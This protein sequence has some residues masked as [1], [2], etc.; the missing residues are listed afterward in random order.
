MILFHTAKMEYQWSKFFWKCMVAPHL[1]DLPN[2]AQIREAT[3]EDLYN[4]LHKKI[5]KINC[6][7]SL[8]KMLRDFDGT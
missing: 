8:L 5:V 7:C 6:N 2:I 4:C 1:M 3:K